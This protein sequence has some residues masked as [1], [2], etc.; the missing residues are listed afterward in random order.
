MR[1]IYLDYNASTPLDLRVAATMRRA[2]E[3]PYGNPSSPH[4]AATSQSSA[5][6]IR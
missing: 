4:W 1:R 6:A 5:F 3:E 2:L